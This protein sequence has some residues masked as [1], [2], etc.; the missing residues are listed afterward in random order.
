[1]DSKQIITIIDVDVSGG[2]RRICAWCKKELDPVDGPAG[3]VT[4]TICPECDRA[5][6]E[7][8]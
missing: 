4:H 1:M 6:M 7:E 8:E 3:S 2:M 5:M